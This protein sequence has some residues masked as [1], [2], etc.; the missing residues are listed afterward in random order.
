MSG[1]AA[2]ELL[3]T[4]VRCVL[5]A[6]GVEERYLR[7]GG[8]GEPPQ[9]VPRAPTDARSEFLANRAMGDWAETVLANAIDS[10]LPGMKA[11]HYGDA[12]RIAAGDEG[13]AEFYRSRLEGV[14]V[15]GKRPDLLVVPAEIHT[16]KDVSAIPTLD[17]ADLVRTANFSIEVRSSKF[18]AKRYMDVKRK[19]SRTGIVSPKDS[20]SF[21]VKVEDLIIVYR[22]MQFF[23]CRQIYAQVFFD[24]VFAINF[25][26]IFQIIASGAGFSIEE[27][28][29]S[30][31]KAT[32][33][34]PISAGIQVGIFHQ[35]PQ[36]TVEHRVTELGRHDAFV[37]PVGGELELYPE[38]IRTIVGN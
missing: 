23:Q 13:F 37:K 21:T 9:K 36:F 12:D 19:R 1:F 22:W 18:E 32:I 3:A 35:L 6:K 20:L 28:E 15:H 30:Q 10:Q 5:E 2:I 17:L 26:T 7:F 11:I 38:P 24:S 31:Q 27:P 33:M 14:R 34:I 16:P 29:R 8:P 25:E 4:S